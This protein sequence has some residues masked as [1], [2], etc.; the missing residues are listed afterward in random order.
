M[1]VSGRMMRS[2]LAWREGLT[3]WLPLEQVAT[4]PERPSP[5]PVPKGLPPVPKGLPPLPPKSRAQ[6]EVPV[7][8]SIGSRPSSTIRTV[9]GVIALILGLLT[10]FNIGGCMNAK[11][12]LA[13]LQSGNDPTDSAQM[14][15]DTFQ[16]ASQGDPLRGVSGMLDQVRSLKD[17]YEGFQLGAWL[18]LVGTVV[19]CGVFRFSQPVKAPS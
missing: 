2:N 15:V 18:C 16:G 17:D 6:A 10:I 14:F 13:R 1:V 7:L 12:K 4:L 3:G 19:A 5:P 8:A 11:S 9:S